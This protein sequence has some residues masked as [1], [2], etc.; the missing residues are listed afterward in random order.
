MKSFARIQ[1]FVFVELIGPV[2]YD[3]ESPDWKPGQPSRIGKEIPISERFTPELVSSMIDITGLIPAPQMGWTYGDG[4][5]SPPAPY[6]PSEMEVVEWNT[7]IRDALLVQAGTAIAPLQDAADLEYATSAEMARL[8]KW[9]QY[10]VAVNRT[11]LTLANPSWP[12]QP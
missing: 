12:P 6:N 11:D 9:K 10:R 8:M 1:D 4:A 3:S 5:F 7:R 2:S